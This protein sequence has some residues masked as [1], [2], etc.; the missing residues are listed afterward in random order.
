MK[1]PV[2]VVVDGTI[3]EVTLNEHGKAIVL[4]GDY[5]ADLPSNL[6]VRIERAA[7]D[8][9]Q[10]TAM[11]NA[12]VMQKDSILQDINAGQFMRA[13]R[14]LAFAWRVWDSSDYSYKTEE[15]IGRL[16]RELADRTPHDEY[17]NNVAFELFAINADRKVF[18]ERGF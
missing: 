1:S 10:E 8:K 7:S 2:V 3:F 17:F 14:K 6:I 5:D 13:V 12:L 18:T 15:I 9:M 4:N 11:D 16:S